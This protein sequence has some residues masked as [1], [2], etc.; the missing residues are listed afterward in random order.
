MTQKDFGK[1][2]R[3]SRRATSRSGRI[4]VVNLALLFAVTAVAVS[5]VLT[6]MLAD[7][8]TSGQFAAR[9]ADVDRMSTGSIPGEHD[10][11]KRYTIRRSVLQET[12]GSVCIVNPG[13]GDAC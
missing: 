6:P 11:G 9:P 2:G 12:P 7:K 13:N 4:G 5:L 8:T 3:Q 10:A 1:G